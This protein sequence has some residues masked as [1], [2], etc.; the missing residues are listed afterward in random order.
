MKNEPPC[1]VIDTNV[2]ISA[3]LLPRS[4]SA[5]V[6]AAAVER[7]VLA[8]N[9]ATWEE[10]V[11]RIERDKFDRYFGENGRLAYLSKL[12]Q[13][14]RFFDAVADVQVSRNA[15]DDK[16]VSLALDAGATLIV[17]GDGDLKDVKVFQGIEI[18]SPSVFLDRFTPPP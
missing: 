17:S 5:L 12:A 13:V 15:D 8:Q 11:S 1:I 10:L 14:A 2:L 6:V 3:G 7:F 16:F 4:R 9:R 18:I